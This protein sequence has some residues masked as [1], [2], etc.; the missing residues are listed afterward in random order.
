MSPLYVSKLVLNRSENKDEAERILGKLVSSRMP[1]YDAFFNVV[2]DSQPIDLAVLS[3]ETLDKCDV[4]KRHVQDNTVTQA[5]AQAQA[6]TEFK[7]LKQLYVPSVTLLDFVTRRGIYMDASQ[8]HNLPK[9]NVKK[10]GAVRYSVPQFMNVLISSYEYLLV[11]VARMQTELELV[12][13]DLKVQNVVLNAYTKKPI[14]I[15]FGLAFSIRDVRAVLDK[16][17][18][19]KGVS[20]L[21]TVLSLKSF[22]YGFHPDYSP[23]ALETHMISY[24]VQTTASEA[25][26]SATATATASNAIEVA[27][28]TKDALVDMVE[29][30]M[31]SNNEYLKGQSENVK[32]AFFDRTMRTYS[33][34]VV[35]KPGLQVIRELLDGE[36]GAASGWKKWDVYSVATLCLDLIQEAYKSYPAS[37]IDPYRTEIERFRTALAVAAGYI[38]H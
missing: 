32:R 1:G 19:G 18:T 11:G 30:Y 36:D 8:L 5:Q 13:Y 6:H 15:D 9:E 24:I 14:I 20:D 12:H 26:A 33:S 38:L 2:V 21:D 35:G 3:P 10:I 23:W 22:F 16:G 34:R 25:A 31:E 29:T 17:T 4:V 27:T 28:I 7:V 37:E